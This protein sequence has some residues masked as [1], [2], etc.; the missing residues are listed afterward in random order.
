MND[1]ELLDLIERQ[2]LRVQPDGMDGWIVRGPIEQF[3]MRQGYPRWGAH[4][5]REALEQAAEHYGATQRG[6]DLPDIVPA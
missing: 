4:R 5:L 3:G 2:K 1:T 6:G